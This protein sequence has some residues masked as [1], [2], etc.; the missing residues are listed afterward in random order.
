MANSALI[1]Y[2]SSITGDCTCSGPTPD[3]A[4]SVFIEGGTGP[5]TAQIISPYTSS[6][7]G[8]L[9][10]GDFVFSGLT[11]GTYTAQITDSSS[12]N[13][14]VAINFYISSYIVKFSSNQIYSS[15]IPISI[16]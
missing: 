11:A 13:Q 16:W 3:G 10:A 7:Y 9:P 8:L 12:I 6:V 2:I 14:I 1:P 4:V 5:F 15:T